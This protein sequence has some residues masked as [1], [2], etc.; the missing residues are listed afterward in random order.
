MLDAPVSPGGTTPAASAEGGASTAGAVESPAS[1]MDTL[2]DEGLRGHQ[3]LTKFKDINGLAKSYV[4]LDKLRNER[5]GVKP[6][7]AESSADEIAAYRQAMGI[8]DAPE[9]Y[10]VGELAFP[11]EA[12]PTQEQL[13][14]FKGIAHSLHLTP[15]QV[16]GILQWYSQ[17]IS[18]QWSTIQEAQAAQ[19]REANATLT[20]KYGAEA[21]RMMQLAHEYVK[22]R[23]GDEGIDAL[24][25]GP[26]ATQALGNNPMLIEILAESAKLTGHD[27]FVLG[28]NRG[29]LLN[30]ANAKQ[31]YDE[32]WIKRAAAKDDAERAAIDAE[33]TRVTPLAFR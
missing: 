4:E 30:Q 10:E 15:A 8:P 20:K 16:Q 23:F 18:Q 17:D 1:W 31:M 6:I 3:G 14:A 24:G 7:T 9:K 26:G 21:P 11:E 22:R 27:Q 2:T 12:T 29:G 28:D 25:F 13:G 32:L 33:I 19:G 5:T